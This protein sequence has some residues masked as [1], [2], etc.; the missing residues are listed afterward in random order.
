VTKR[1]EWRREA[2]QVHIVEHC[3]YA[4][5]QGELELAGEEVVVDRAWM[6]NVPGAAGRVPSASPG[7]LAPRTCSCSPWRTAPQGVPSNRRWCWPRTLLGIGICIWNNRFQA[8]NSEERIESSRKL[9]DLPVS[10]ETKESRNSALAHAFET[11]MGLQLYITRCRN[12]AASWLLAISWSE[13]SRWWLP[14]AFIDTN[15][16]SAAANVY[17]GQ[18]QVT[19]RLSKWIYWSKHTETTYSSRSTTSAQSPKKM[20][21]K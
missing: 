13:R 15:E 1:V 7:A 8:L 6:D 14:P 21:G 10:E 19:G 12:D 18:I 9:L 3:N 2:R 17:L 5:L 16:A 11:S 4:S 20:L